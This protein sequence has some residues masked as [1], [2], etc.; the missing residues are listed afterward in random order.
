MNKT[1]TIRKVVTFA[2]LTISVVFSLLTGIFSVEAKEVYFDLSLSSSA[3]VISASG[4]A[5]S[6]E[7]TTD[8]P[9]GSTV[10]ITM[11]VVNHS[12]VVDSKILFI[13]KEGIK[14]KDYYKGVL[15]INGRNAS[16]D[17]YTSYL[18]SGKAIALNGTKTT[19]ELEVITIG[20]SRDKISVDMKIS[21]SG[22]TMGD[23]SET[24]EH[25]FRGKFAFNNTT[26]IVNF[27]DGEILLKQVKVKNNQVVDAPIVS[28]NGY[29]FLGFNT[30]LDGKGFFY[31][32]EKIKKSMNLYATF[33]IKQYRVSYYVDNELYYQTFVNYGEDGEA[34][35]GPKKSN[36]TFL[37]W[38]ENLH[39]ITEDTVVYAL[40]QKD[41]ISKSGLSYRVDKIIEGSMYTEYDSKIISSPEKFYIDFFTKLK[42]N[43]EK[44]FPFKLLIS[45]IPFIISLLIVLIY[46]YYQKRKKVVRNEV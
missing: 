31:N 4:Q 32:G 45:A 22:I 9:Y 39:N 42:I 10:K 20:S 21:S 11:N 41:E 44:S 1:G 13:E 23:K 15:K 30:Q 7:S 19:Y 18:N 43:A 36:N 33:V 3:K 24:Y 46:L 38:S 25:S 5:Y 6:L 2:V 8:V 17:E 16:Q 37:G 12:G 26:H 29:N 34:I 35:V 27:Y 40:Y 14:F 28:K